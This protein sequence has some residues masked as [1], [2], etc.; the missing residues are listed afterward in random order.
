MNGNNF[1]ADT[2]AVLYLL[3]GNKCMEKYIQEN[4]YVSVIS[5]MELLGFPN[6][7]QEETSCI[8]K[9]LINCSECNISESIKEKTIELRKKYNIKLPDAIIAATA[10]CNKIP[11]LSADIIFNRI[12]ELEFIL[13]KP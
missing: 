6:I 13:L 8:R 5:E 4:L 1:V 9:F 3:V 2:N 10:V 12:E 7:S 11:L